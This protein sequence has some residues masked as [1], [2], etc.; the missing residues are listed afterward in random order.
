MPS[1]PRELSPRQSPS[2]FEVA[3]Y[4]PELI[5]DLFARAERFEKN[6]HVNGYF[7]NPKHRVVGLLFFEPSTRTRLSFQMAA[8]RLGYETLHFDNASSSLSKG[9]S[10]SDTVLNLVA[11]GPDALVIRYG[12]SPELDQLLPTLPVPVINAGSGIASHPTQALLDAF[13]I[14]REKGSFSGLKVL[15]VGDIRHSRV[16]RSNFDV[17]TRLG[18]TVAVCGPPEFIQKNDLPTQVKVFESLDEAVEWC[19]IY[20]G[21]R[22]QLERHAESGSLSN[23]QEIA[24][25]HSSF[26]LTQTRLQKLKKD[27]IILHPGPINHGV[28]FASGASVMKDPRN[29]VLQQ[30]TNGVLIRASLLA[31]IFDGI[32]LKENA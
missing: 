5:E 4:S 28:E 30:V 24:A 19:D 6:V 29:R 8:Q 20:M 31:Q 11:M 27:A 9:E 15:I 32:S 18:A 10:F 7:Q 26:G 22:V 16:A 14:Y 12:I 23:D 3:S 1:L 13:T 2:L 17:L 21:L 25:Y